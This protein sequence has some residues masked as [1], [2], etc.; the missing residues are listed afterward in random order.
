M[1]VSQDCISR[2]NSNV[3]RLKHG[4][5]VR[6]KGLCKT[7]ECCMIVNLQGVPSAERIDNGSTPPGLPTG[8]CEE[9][10]ESH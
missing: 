2:C 6:L 10:K 7:C 1:F 9:K 4:N 8:Y 3:D 5:S